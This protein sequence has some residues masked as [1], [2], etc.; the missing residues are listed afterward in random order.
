MVELMITRQTI[1]P[2]W[3]FQF[4]WMR[5]S[6]KWKLC[7]IRMGLRH[8]GH[9]LTKTEQNYIPE[10]LMLIPIHGAVREPTDSLK[11]IRCVWA[12]DAIPSKFTIRPVME[13]VVAMETAA[14]LFSIT[15]EMKYLQEEISESPMPMIFV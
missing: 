13:F 15:S 4:F 7:W 10:V 2:Q 3:R 9:Y 1:L 8:P 14:T 5:L 6:M 11:N 12:P